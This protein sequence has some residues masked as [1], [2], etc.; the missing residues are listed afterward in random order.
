VAVYADERAVFLR[1]GNSHPPVS[2]RIEQLLRQLNK[3]DQEYARMFAVP[4]SRATEAAAT[5]E[6]TAVTFNWRN[7]REIAPNITT[8]QPDTY[9]Q[10]IE[11]LDRLLSLSES[12]LIAFLTGPDIKPLVG[13]GIQL[14]QEGKA[15]AALHR[16]GVPSREA[17]LICDPSIPLAFST[18]VAA[19]REGFKAVDLPPVQ[20]L[21]NAVAAAALAAPL[22]ARLQ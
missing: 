1:Q 12:K 17:G 4:L 13:D 10:Q 8:P 21:G 6:P 5:F 9:L 18:L 3:S 14:L 2:A 7:L 15:D 22:L 16:W 20:H 19:L 11:M